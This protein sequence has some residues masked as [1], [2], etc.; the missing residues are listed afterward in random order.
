MHALL[1]KGPRFIPKARSLSTTEVQTAC[2]RLGYRLVRAFERYVDGGYHEMRMQAM[3]EEGIR[4][5]TP[6]Q[7][8]LPASFC[9]SYVSSFFKCQRVDGGAW[10]SN[11]LLSPF[12]DRCIRNIE[13]DH[14]ILTSASTV[15]S[16]LAARL[17][18]PNL[19]HAE[20]AVLKSVLSLDVGYNNAD[21][22]FTPEN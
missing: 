2:A 12:F 1:G 8:Q 20:F 14:D 13:Y 15:Q 11:Q 4:L 3:K 19:N 21:L 6:R 17:K 22:L 5:W 9:H 18:R 10:R 7:R 16:D